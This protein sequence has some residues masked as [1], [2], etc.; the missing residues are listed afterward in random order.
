LRP[1][2]ICCGNKDP[3]D[4]YNPDLQK[5]LKARFDVYCVDEKKEEEDYIPMY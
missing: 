2:V 4:I 5:Y 1:I 3:K